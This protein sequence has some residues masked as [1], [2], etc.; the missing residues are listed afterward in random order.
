MLPRRVLSAS[1]GAA[2]NNVFA[3][4]VTSQHPRRGMHFTYVPDAKPPV[5]G[6]TEKMTMLQVRNKGTHG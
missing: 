1:L 3:A 5:D 4:A 2:R 6:P